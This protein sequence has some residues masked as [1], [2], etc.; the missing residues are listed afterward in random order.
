MPQ[1]RVIALIMA[2]KLEADPFIRELGLERE[3][4]QP[5]L[6]YRRD[7][8][9]LIISGIGKA[10][11]AIAATY[12]ILTYRPSRLCNLGAAGAVTP[13]YS[14]GD[15]YHIDAVIEYDRPR[16]RS[17]KIRRLTPLVLPGFRC[18][19]LATQDKPAVDPDHRKLLTAC[20]D[21][22][23]MEAAG[24]LQAAE[25]FSVPCVIFKF[26]SDTVDHCEH[27]V[28]VAHIKQYGSAFCSWVTA[29]VL[30]L[31]SQRGPGL[32]M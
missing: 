25:K 14:L 6:V 27:D 12:G 20:A 24:V 31:L 18:A 13:G 9:V 17:H 1:H 28:I 7:D 3:T 29:S 8:V 32:D 26:V 23:D 21:L 15:M 19:V 10:N 4:K 22:V 30:P 2:T 5:F 16:L 11:A